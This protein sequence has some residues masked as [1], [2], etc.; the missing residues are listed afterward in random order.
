MRGKIMKLKKWDSLP[1]LA[2]FE[3][4]K[5]G[6]PHLHLVLRSGFIAQ[7]Q[8]SALAMQFLGSPIVH[9]RIIDSLRH[10]ARYIG[11]YISKQNVRFG[12]CKRYWKSKDYH[13]GRKKEWK[14]P[15]DN[16]FTWERVHHCVITMAEALAIEG[17]EVSFDD[18]GNCTARAP[19][20]ESKWQRW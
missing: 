14:R 12:T 20:K 17:W 11:K 19:P 4:H 18:K 2:V 10:A 16:Q 1:F 3:A 5:S 13:E 15:D 8:L 9:I 7:R 6:W